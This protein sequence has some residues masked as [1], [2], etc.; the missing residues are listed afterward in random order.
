MIVK[1][2]SAAAALPIFGRLPAS[3]LP[4][5]PK[6]SSNLPGVISR[7]VVSTLRIASSVWA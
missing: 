2:A 3:R 7:N 4:P 5:Q 1:S 6:A